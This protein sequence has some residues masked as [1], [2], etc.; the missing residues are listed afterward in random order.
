MSSVLP[1]RIRSMPDQY[2][3]GRHKR[4]GPSTPRYTYARAGTNRRAGQCNARKV[5]FP[6][7]SARAL[8]PWIFCTPQFERLINL[9]PEIIHR[10]E[11]ISNCAGPIHVGHLSG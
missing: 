7:L 8:R 10:P 9:I 3:L 1:D 2:H 5:H 4:L 11:A 6:F